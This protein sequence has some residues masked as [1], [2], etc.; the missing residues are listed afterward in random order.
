ML[1][2]IITCVDK[3]PLFAQL[4]RFEISSQKEQHVTCEAQCDIIVLLFLEH[5]TKNND[6]MKKNHECAHI[7]TWYMYLLISLEIQHICSQRPKRSTCISILFFL[8]L[9]ILISLLLKSRVLT[10]I[11]SSQASQSRLPPL[12]V[13]RCHGRSCETK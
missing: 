13:R 4:W 7:T 10:N 6:H 12:L 5:L 9:A 2:Q 8:E 1:L 11:C 3:D